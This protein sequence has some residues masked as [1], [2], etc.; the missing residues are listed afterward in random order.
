MLLEVEAGLDDDGLLGVDAERVSP[1]LGSTSSD[2]TITS[3]V[4]GGAAQREGFLQVTE[5]YPP[6]ASR[7]D[8]DSTRASCAPH[9]CI[10]AQVGD[11][12]VSLEGQKLR[13]AR[14]DAVLAEVCAEIQK[15][16]STT[17]MSR[18]RRRTLLVE[19]RLGADDDGVS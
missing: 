18:R 16:K 11:T 1:R 3:M 8:A 15:S 13:G 14:P 17:A 12:I 7:L 10:T 5:G 9:S 4:D 6:P 19:R 2:F